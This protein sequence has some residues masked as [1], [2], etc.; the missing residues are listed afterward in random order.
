[1]QNYLKPKKKSILDTITDTIGTG[2][3]PGEDKNKN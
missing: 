3:E 2:Y 1:M